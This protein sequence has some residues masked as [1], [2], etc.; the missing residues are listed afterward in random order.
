MK[1]YAN[2]QEMVMFL[3]DELFKK[4]SLSLIFISLVLS[5][6]FAI[7]IGNHFIPLFWDRR[8]FIQIGI[9]LIATFIQ[10]FIVFILINK[11]IWPRFTAIALVERLFLM[12]LLLFIVVGKFIIMDSRSY[13]NQF[14]NI[15][16]NGADILHFSFYIF[17]LI[18][19]S[20]VMGK[21]ASAIRLRKN[22]SSIYKFGS[23][24]LK[25]KQ[26]FWFPVLFLGLCFIGIF[27]INNLLPLIDITLKQFDFPK[28]VSTFQPVGIDFRGGLYWPA[29]L[30]LSDFYIY[31]KP[32][33]ILNLYPPLSTVLSLPYLLL[34]EDNAYILHTFLLFSTNIISLIFVTLIAKDYVF[35]NFDLSKVWVNTALSVTFLLILFNLLTGYPFLFSFER[36]NIDIFALFFSIGSTWVLL[37]YPNRIWFQVVLLSI[38]VHIKIYPVFLFAVLFFKNRFKIIVPSI[39]VNIGFLLILGPINAVE[40]IKTILDFMKND[41]NISGIANHSS[42]S[43]AEILAQYP[44]IS[45]YLPFLKLF[46]TFFPLIIWI[47]AWIAIFRIKDIEKGIVL[48]FMITIPLMEV[49]PSRSNDYKLV[50]LSSAIIILVFQILKKMIDNQNFFDYLQLIIISIIVLFIGRSSVLLGS[51]LNIIQ[52]KYIW[53]IL[54]EIL[55]LLNI[56]QQ[57]NSDVFEGN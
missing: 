35:S 16:L 8:V 34:S 4:K 38:A 26:C 12:L 13:E 19:L 24:K 50:I 48:G 37:K 40:F 47:I 30:L 54:L 25:Q 14:W 43:F 3:K 39:I 27:Y 21:D 51:S 2:H 32:E 11:I 7:S 28:I 31:S 15:L 49:L 17:A 10:S 53:I 33:E 18:S 36:G 6:F 29:K 46:F 9:I 57:S 44:P 20:N 52:N 55:M 42:S 23:I 56:I 22:L 5:L 1:K 41:S 45:S